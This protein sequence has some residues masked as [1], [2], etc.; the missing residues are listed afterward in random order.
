MMDCSY[1]L[2]SSEV[3]SLRVEG[4]NRRL[5]RA[6]ATEGEEPVGVTDEAS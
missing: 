2:E 3:A 1:R 4:N 6:A 5:R